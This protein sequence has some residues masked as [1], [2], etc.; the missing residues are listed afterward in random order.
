MKIKQ[1]EIENGLCLLLPEFMLYLCANDVT[2]HIMQSL[3][4]KLQEY[5]FS[6]KSLA[7]DSR[8]YIYSH[9]FHRKC[10]RDTI[11]CL[12]LNI[13]RAVENITAVHEMCL[14]I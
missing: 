7:V 2:I 6:I 14:N 12:L 13:V 9:V 3:W 8:S 1:S 11:R 4:L 5:F 10:R